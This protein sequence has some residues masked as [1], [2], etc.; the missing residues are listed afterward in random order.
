MS[1]SVDNTLPSQERVLRPRS[2]KSI[3]AIT[4]ALITCG[5]IALS[6]FGWR[7]SVL[8]LIGV[9]LGMSLF[10]YSF[11][12]ASAYRKLIVNRDVS[13][14]YAQLIMLGA[15]TILFAPVLANGSIFGQQVKGTIAPVGVQGAIGAFLFGIGMQLGGACGCG[16]LYTIGSGSL[17]MLITLVAFCIGSFWASVTRQIWAN[18]HAT[19]PIVFGQTLGWLGAV[20][21]QLA[22]FVLLA[23]ILWLWSKT[24]RQEERL[25]HR[26]YLPLPLIKAAIAL[27]V[28][29]WLT[30]IISGQPWR[31]TWGF[32]LW[33]A[34]I[35]TFLG[36]DLSDSP[37]W[38]G[39][40]QQTALS[41]SVFAD[42]TSVMNIG[43]ILG[44]LLAAA[45][46]GR[47]I[48]Q[49]QIPLMTAAANLLGGLVMGYGALLAFGC[50]VSAFFGG[51]ASTS[52]HGWVWIICALLGTLLGVRLRSVFK[53]QK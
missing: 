2:Q 49:T 36:W 14:I 5:T 46:A 22:L 43:I 3:V 47:L 33:A 19:E 8:F 35:A 15:A 10:N 18:L 9:L 53:L 29:N 45:F 17:S 41:E 40:V 16:T 51:I 30:L 13:F 42:V 37:F 12:F 25:P 28:L 39:K 6:N 20:F 38:S 44:A 32:V 23:N 24:K 26:P 11:G 1:S 34:K 48:F 31:I 7:Q 52:L 27:A 21:L 4:L 50:N